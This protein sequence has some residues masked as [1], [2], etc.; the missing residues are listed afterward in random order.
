MLSAFGEPPDSGV[1]VSASAGAASN[2]A[3]GAAANAARIRRR[4][5]PEGKERRIISPLHAEVA[6]LRIHLELP[7]A[8]AIDLQLL[9]PHVGDPPPAHEQPSDRESADRDRPDRYRAGGLRAHGAGDACPRAPHHAPWKAAS[10]FSMKA[11][12]PSWKSRVRASACWRS[13]SSESWPRRSG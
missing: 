3:A 10:R 8:Q 6:A 4:G 5:M 9:D 1:N 7:Y 12:A 11:S 13:A 2:R